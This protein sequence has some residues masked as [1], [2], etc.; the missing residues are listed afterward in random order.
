MKHRGLCSCKRL[1]IWQFIA[2]SADIAQLVEQLIRNQQVTGSSPVVG[3]LQAWFVWII[4]ESNEDGAVAMALRKMGFA[5]ARLLAKTA[6]P[7][8]RRFMMEAA[9]P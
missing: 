9:A 4:A 3:S 6:G 1:H 5:L 8:C 2:S 7:I